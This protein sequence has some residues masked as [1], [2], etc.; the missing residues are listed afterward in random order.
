[1]DYKHKGKRVLL[2][3]MD[4]ELSNL[5]RISMLDGIMDCDMFKNKSM[6][7]SP[8]EV[9]YRKINGRKIRSYV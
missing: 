9:I 2:I 7:V 6:I 4:D 1:M 8:K 5:E 3:K